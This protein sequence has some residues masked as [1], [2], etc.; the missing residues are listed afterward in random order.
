MKKGI[1]A[2]LVPIIFLLVGIV[3]GVG[4]IF[5]G[6]WGNYLFSIAFLVFGGV[7]LHTSLRGKISAY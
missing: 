6:A 2:P 7:Y 4:A 5:S 1:D 3:G